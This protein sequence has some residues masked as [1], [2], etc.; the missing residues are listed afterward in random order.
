MVAYTFHPGYKMYRNAYCSPH[1]QHK[2]WR[3][4]AQESGDTNEQTHTTEHSRDNSQ[5]HSQQTFSPRADI[6][7]DEHN[8]Y[9]FIEI[10]GMGKDD[11]TLSYNSEDRFLTVRGEKKAV[12]STEGLKTLRHER[13]FGSFERK[14]K[15]SSDVNVDISAINAVFEHGLLT[16]T[17]PK[18]QPKTTTIPIV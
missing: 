4:Y 7:R 13:Q 1:A 3:K 11:V 6:A 16:I 2:P 17:L 18:I 10:P 9:L 5:Q 12:E 8:I 14:F 15:L